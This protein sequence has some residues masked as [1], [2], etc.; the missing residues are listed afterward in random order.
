ML[1]ENYKIP[2][3]ILDRFKKKTYYPEE[4]MKSSSEKIGFF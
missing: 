4:F 3:E 1:G 2:R